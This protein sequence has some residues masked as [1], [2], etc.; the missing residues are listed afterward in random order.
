MMPCK[1]RGFSN[2]VYCF[3]RLAL[4]GAMLLCAAG[5]PA[6]ETAQKRGAI[7]GNVSL[8]NA[9]QERATSEGLL[10]EL[11]PLAEGAPS[12]STVTDEAGNYEFKDVA[13][14]DYFLRL[15][16]EGFEPFTA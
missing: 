6:Q 8:L 16:T 13:E 3:V 11:K 14:G 1:A 12:L 7:K 9:S 15:Q 2:T 5:M 4:L 10:L